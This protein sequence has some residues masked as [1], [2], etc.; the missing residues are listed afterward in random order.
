MQTLWNLSSI[1]KKFLIVNTVCA[2]SVLES[3]EGTLNVPD[4]SALY[5]PALS[6]KERAIVA[7]HYKKVAARLNA[8][9]FAPP[10][11][12]QA[13]AAMPYMVDGEY[14]C[15]PWWW[16][17]SR[18]AFEAAVRLQGFEILGSEIWNNH[19]LKFFLKRRS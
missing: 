17:F 9:R 6:G 11:D 7:G 5:M 14:S 10:I 1:T 13:T 16:L 8:D 2:P 19:T 12:S 15:M 18:K 4:A 3:E